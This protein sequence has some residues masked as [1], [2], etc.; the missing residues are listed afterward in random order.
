MKE[1][2]KKH[3]SKNKNVYLKYVL[4]SFGQKFN[5]E[6]IENLYNTLL[7]IYKNEDPIMIYSKISE[8]ADKLKQKYK[9][10]NRYLQS[11]AYHILIGSTPDPNLI[12][13]FDFEGEDS[14]VEFIKD[15]KKWIDRPR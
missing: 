5:K 12:T 14:I 2:I 3:K 9:E 4:E 1:N 11:L 6:E 8:F 13:F 7:E 15:L 10:E